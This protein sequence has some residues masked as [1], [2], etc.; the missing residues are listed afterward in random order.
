[1]IKQ[2]LSMLF[3]VLFATSMMAQTTILDFEAPVTSGTFQY[4]G[5]FVN[6]HP[7]PTT[8]VIPNPDQSGINTSAT[9]SDFVKPAFAEVWSGAFANPPLQVPVVTSNGDNQICVKVWMPEIGNL[10]L[11]L[12]ASTNGGPNWITTQSNTVVNE[13]EELCFNINDPSL[14]PP[15]TGVAGFDYSVITL[16]FDF[17]VSPAQTRNYFFDDIVVGT[18]AQPATIPTMGQWSLFAFALIMLIVGVVFVMQ[19]QSNLQLS[20]AGAGNTPAPKF[21]LK[22]FPFE[23]KGFNQAFKYALLLVPFGFAFIYIVWGEIV[24]DDV[25]GMMFSLPLVAY[26]IYLVRKK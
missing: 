25:V 23:W 7:T 10:S 1:M 13:W 6:P 3:A 4:F 18:A 2:V 19:Y 8:N 12:E 15:F 21:S 9:V 22:S 14:E 11:K 17:G 16:F 26:L 24:F 5:S 20:V